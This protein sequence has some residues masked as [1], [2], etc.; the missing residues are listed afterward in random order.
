MPL[1][2]PQQTCLSLEMI[3]LQPPVHFIPLYMIESP[4][5]LSE[6]IAIARLESDRN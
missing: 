3:F 4:K 1:T 2:L 5:S 6:E